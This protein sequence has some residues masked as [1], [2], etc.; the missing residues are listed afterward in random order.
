M[1][2]VEC[3]LKYPIYIKKQQEENDEEDTYVSEF[4]MTFLGRTVKI[5]WSKMEKELVFHCT[6][7]TWNALPFSGYFHSF[8]AYKKSLALIITYWAMPSCVWHIIGIPVFIA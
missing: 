3:S 5:W 6:A 2:E 8:K 4:A 1:K 7:V